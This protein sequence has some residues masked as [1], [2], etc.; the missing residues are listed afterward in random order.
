M[1]EESPREGEVLLALSLL[2]G[3]HEQLRTHMR[4][5]QSK[6]VIRQETFLPSVVE[7]L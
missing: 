4:A 5:E 1:S 6:H 7:T 2:R 3:T